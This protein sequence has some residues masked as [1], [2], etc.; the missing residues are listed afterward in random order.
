MR[1]RRWATIV[2]LCLTFSSCCNAQ[3]LLVAV[4]SNF[5]PT[6]QLLADQFKTTNAIDIKLSSASTGV[7]FAQIRQGAPFDVFL[8]ADTRHVQALQEAGLSHADTRIT[9]A[10]GELVLISDN[11]VVIKND[12]KLT[13]QNLRQKKQQIAIANPSTAPYGR[14]ARETLQQLGTW[15]AVDKN[16]IRAN[17]VAQSMHYVAAQTVRAALTARSLLQHAKLADNLA[18]VAVP[19]YLHAPI[20]QQAVVLH[21]APHVKQAKAF[22]QFLRSEA[23]RKLISDNGYLLPQLPA[24]NDTL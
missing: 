12:L 17:N 2:S 3:A 24:N 8:A 20:E 22:I 9:Y 13:L 15:E 10:I 14:A 6:A 1:I 18:I 5:K 4:A 16:V 11:E 21:Q 19:Q 7:L 23:A